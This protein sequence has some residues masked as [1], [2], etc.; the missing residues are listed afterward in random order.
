[1]LVKGKGRKTGYWP[2]TPPQHRQIDLVVD[3]GRTTA[4]MILFDR[5]SLPRDV[6]SCI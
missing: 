1:M 5:E 4:P 3:Y 6:T 2:S